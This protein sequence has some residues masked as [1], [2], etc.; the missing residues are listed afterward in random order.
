[1]QS[2]LVLLSRLWLIFRCFYVSI[3]NMKITYTLLYI[4]Y[5]IYT[6]IYLYEWS[7][8]KKT[9]SCRSEEV[10]RS[11]S[12]WVIF[13]SLAKKAG[14]VIIRA[15]VT[16]SAEKKYDKRIKTNKSLPKT[17]WIAYINLTRNHQKCSEEDGCLDQWKVWSAVGN[18]F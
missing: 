4:T 5:N 6:Y 3:S 12:K 9:L 15:V 13:F 8:S 16:E 17:S 10:V 14:P 11:F 1:M 2:V 18:L 7:H